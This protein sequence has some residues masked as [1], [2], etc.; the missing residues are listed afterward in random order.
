MASERLSKLQ[1]WILMFCYE[2]KHCPKTKRTDILEFYY[3]W[4]TKEWGWP[5]NRPKF[6]E[7]N[8]GSDYMKKQVTVSRSLKRLLE[9]DLIKRGD[10]GRKALTFFIPTQKGL[11]TGK[12]LMLNKSNLYLYLTI[13][14]NFYPNKEVAIRLHKL[15]SG[16]STIDTRAKQTTP[17]QSNQINPTKPN[18]NKE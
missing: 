2:S 12:S 1:K 5:D 18:T 11:D 4:K 16:V 9:K 14:N 15:D 3:G 7:K 6:K 8:I 10:D 17:P 13:R